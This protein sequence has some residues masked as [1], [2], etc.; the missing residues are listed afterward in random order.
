MTADPAGEATIRPPGGSALVVAVAL[1]ACVGVTLPRFL[2]DEAASIR[3]MSLVPALVAT[4]WWLIP[5]FVFVLRVRSRAVLVVGA[6]AYI[7]TA[8]LS[9]AATYRNDHS[10]A[11]FGIFFVPPL[12]IA[13]VAIVLALD[14]WLARP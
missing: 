5:L 1:V 8:G 6:V 3:H 11:A 9:L 2:F 12:L 10:T 13:A 14:R 7:S 4:V